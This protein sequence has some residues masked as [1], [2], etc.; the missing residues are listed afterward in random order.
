MKE[1]A[2]KKIKDFWGQLVSLGFDCCPEIFNPDNHM[3][4]PYSAAEVNSAC[5]AWSCT[6]S[7]FIRKFTNEFGYSPMKYFDMLRAQ[8]AMK[9][10]ESSDIP[11]EE[12]AKKIGI[13]DKY[14]FNRFF[15]KHCDM[16]PIEY[17]KLFNK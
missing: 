15:Y 4:S 3:E 7:Y 9:L 5:H 11:T 16:M 13:T 10:L 14:Y 12:V 17:R 6:P 8:Q 1:Q 2:M